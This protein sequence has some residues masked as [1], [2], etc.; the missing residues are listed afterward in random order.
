MGGGGP[1]GVDRVILRELGVLISCVF[2]W[3][4]NGAVAPHNL[5]KKHGTPTMY[6]SMQTNS[7]V[8]NTMVESELTWKDSRGGL[9]VFYSTG[10]K[11]SIVSLTNKEILLGVD[12]KSPMAGPC[13]YF[14]HF[15]LCILHSLDCSL[16]QQIPNH[17][18]NPK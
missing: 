6:I 7:G 12:N 2:L 4:N 16:L 17:R 9:V 10:V 15:F 11:G 1:G 8:G 3:H 5:A 13:A 18:I 14:H